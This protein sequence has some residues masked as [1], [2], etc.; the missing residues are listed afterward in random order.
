MKKVYL[1]GLFLLVSVFIN[2]CNTGGSY[3]PS[4]QQQ[5][6][7]PTYLSKQAAEQS[8]LAF[9]GLGLSGEDNVKKT[10]QTSHREGS[11]WYVVVV[12]QQGKRQAEQLTFELDAVKG[13]VNCV[14]FL[15]GEKMCGDEL[16]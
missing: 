11:T 2:A 10:I 8:A 6:Q 5:V 15:S 1:V 16:R 3:S 9:S 12:L 14:V 4:Q 13:T 7:Q